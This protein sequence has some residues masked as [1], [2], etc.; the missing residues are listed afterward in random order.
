MDWI[1]RGSVYSFSLMKT[2]SNSAMNR[3]HNSLSSHPYFLNSSSESEFRVDR[4]CHVTPN[5]IYGLKSLTSIS[6]H[7]WHSL[8]R[9]RILLHIAYFTLAGLALVL[10]LLIFVSIKVF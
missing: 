9:A 4:S 7:S 8:E 10:A 1:G 6:W 2:A 3:I 5:A